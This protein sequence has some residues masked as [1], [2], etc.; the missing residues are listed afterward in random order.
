MSAQQVRRL[1]VIS[2]RRPLDPPF[3]LSRKSHQWCG[4]VRGGLK[5]RPRKLCYPSR[6][7]RWRLISPVWRCSCCWQYPQPLSFTLTHPWIASR[8]GAAT[9][10]SCVELTLGLVPVVANS[11]ILAS[12]GGQPVCSTQDQSGRITP[13]WQRRTVGVETATSPLI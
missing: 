8:G 7:P 9:G 13:L 5:T 11:T 2:I 6:S 12:I 10:T 3:P 4:S 1:W